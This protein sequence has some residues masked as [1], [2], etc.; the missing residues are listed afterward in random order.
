VRD[1]SNVTYLHRHKFP[2]E[3]SRR[4]QQSPAKTIRTAS[5]DD[6]AVERDFNKRKNLIQ[7]FSLSKAQPKIHVEQKDHNKHFFRRFLHTLD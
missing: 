3:S 1:K 4:T 6:N 2:E 7:E 5:S